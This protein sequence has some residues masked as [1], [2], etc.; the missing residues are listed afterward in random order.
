MLISSID[1][2]WTNGKTEVVQESALFAKK[3]SSLLLFAV[4]TRNITAEAVGVLFA[5]RAGE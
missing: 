2:L 5:T 1:T 3:F 4:L